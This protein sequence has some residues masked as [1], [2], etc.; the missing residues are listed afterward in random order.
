MLN[1]NSIKS[2]SS[3]SA[4]FSFGTP[5]ANNNKTSANVLPNS[6][7]SVNKNNNKFVPVNNFGNSND[8]PG[9]QDGFKDFNFTESQINNPKT[10]KTPKY[11]QGPKNIEVKRERSPAPMRFRM[12]DKNGDHG[13]VENKRSKTWWGGLNIFCCGNRDKI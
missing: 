1:R 3:R 9:H 6:G 2:N 8:K 12:N 13:K 7:M 4:G 10:P 5:G 11:D